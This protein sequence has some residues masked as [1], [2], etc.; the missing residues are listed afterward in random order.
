MGGNLL[1]LQSAQGG[2]SLLCDSV[3]EIAEITISLVSQMLKT[4]SAEPGNESVDH[5]PFFLLVVRV[6][7]KGRITLL[8]VPFS[9]LIAAAAT[10]LR[11]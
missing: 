4:I 2:T 8:D 10:T 5:T 7:L 11:L 3:F 1:Q 6:Q 9:I